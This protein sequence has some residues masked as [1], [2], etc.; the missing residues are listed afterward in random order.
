MHTN[1]DLDAVPSSD[2]GIFGLPYTEDESNVFLIPARWG[3]TTSYGGGTYD[4]PEAILRASSQIDYFH[5]SYGS[6][7]WKVKICMQDLSL[8]KKQYVIGKQMRILAQKHIAHLE[9]R[10]KI[11]QKNLSKINSACETFL[12]SIERESSRRLKE[13]K[14]VGLV[15][16]DH[17]TPLGLI[18]ALAKVNDSFGILQIDAHCDLRDAYEGFTYSHASIMRNSLKLPQVVKLVQ[19]GIRDFSVGEYEYIASNTA[20]ISTFFDADLKK[21]EFEGV[22][23]SKKVSEIISKLPDQVYISFDID[24]LDPSLCPGTGTPVPG[25]LSFQQAMYLVRS[26]A[27]SGRKI[28]GFDV[29]EVSTTNNDGEWNANVGMRV[30]W[31]LCLWSAKSARISIS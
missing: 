28:I 19:V 18:R 30:L 9:D 8:W 21:S 23:W 7:A 24:G 26:V 20:R 4:G 5:E 16:G 31:N 6:E 12:G 10:K 1:F 27:E 2:A 17:S 3:V 25:G 22:L 13:G 14:L 29:N 11:D 15:G